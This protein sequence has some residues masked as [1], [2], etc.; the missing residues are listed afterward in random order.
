MFIRDREE[1]REQRHMAMPWITASTGVLVGC[2]L[3]GVAWS[4]STLARRATVEAGETVLVAS[5]KN[6]GRDCTSAP[7]PAFRL[8]S[9]PQSGSVATRASTYL[10]EG[11]PPPGASDCRGRYLPGI[12]IYYTPAPDFHGEDGFTYSIT[13]GASRPVMTNYDVTVTVR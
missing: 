10:V 13:I 8:I 9:P 11:A 5:Y 4:A 7:N 3:A 6:W 2:V 1:H 12:G